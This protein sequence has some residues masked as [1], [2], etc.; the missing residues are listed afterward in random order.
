MHNIDLSHCLIVKTQVDQGRL[1]RYNK[2]NKIIEN[3]IT[4]YNKWIRSKGITDQ[5]ELLPHFSCHILRHT[6]A[7]RLLESGAAIKFISAQ[8]GHSDIQITYDNYIDV[9]DEF[10]RVQI[11]PFEEYM[12]SVLGET[13]SEITDLSDYISL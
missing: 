7:T 1:L 2:L 3:I 13:S 12:D 5:N 6:Y 10:K 11:R 4:D 9:T 8:M